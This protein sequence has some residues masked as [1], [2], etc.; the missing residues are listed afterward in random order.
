LATHRWLNL[1]P[2]F[3]TAANLELPHPFSPKAMGLIIAPSRTTPQSWQNSL[4]PIAPYH[5]PALLIDTTDTNKGKTDYSWLSGPSRKL[6]LCLTVDHCALMGGLCLPPGSAPGSLIIGFGA[7]KQRD[8]DT[9]NDTQ[10]C[11]GIE[12]REASVL[13]FATPKE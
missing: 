10:S 7:P 5:S 11:V 3:A 9:C 13:N 1:A 8:G 2:R 4:Q 12:S 6:P